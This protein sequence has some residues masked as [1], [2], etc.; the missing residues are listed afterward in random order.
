MRLISIL[1]CCLAACGDSN[2]AKDTADA[3]DDDGLIEVVPPMDVAADT[4]DDS[5][6]AITDMA[7]PDAIADI[8]VDTGP[9]LPQVEAGTSDSMPVPQAT[10][11]DAAIGFRVNG[12]VHPA[13]RPATWYVEYGATADYGAQT[14]AR[15]LPGRLAAHFREDWTEG[16]NGWNGGFQGTSLVPRVEGDRVFLRYTDMGAAE[17]DVN[18]LDGVGLIHL[19]MYGYPGNV[20]SGV[21]EQPSLYLGGG[22]PDLRGAKM[23]MSVRGVDWV[24]KGTTLGTWTQMDLDASMADQV[25]VR[26]ANWAHT[27]EPFGDLLLSGDW[28]DAHWTLRNRTVDWTYSGQYGARNAY[29][30]KELDGALG[31]VNVDIF[32]AQLLYVDMFDLPS[33]GFD[34]DTL[35]IDFRNHSVVIPSNGGSLVTSPAEGGDP[36]ALVDGFRFGDSHEWIG[37]AAPGHVFRYTLARPVTLTSV[38]IHNSVTAPSTLVEV[39]VSDDGE[40]FVSIGA[41]EI[42]TTSPYGPN[43]LFHHQFELDPVTTRELPLHDKPIVA[44]EVEILAG[45]EGADSWGLGEIEA[46]GAGAIEETED[47]WYDVNL[48]VIVPPGNYHHRIVVTTD[49]GSAHGDD[50]AIEV[51][52]PSAPT[53]ETVIPAI[54]PVAGGEY[55]NIYGTDLAHQLSIQVGGITFEP[56]GVARGIMAVEMPPGHGSCDITITTEFGTVTSEAAVAYDDGT[57]LADPGPCKLTMP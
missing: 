38:L 5:A 24:P 25:P 10:E 16:L 46:Y 44:L 52:T 7:E 22:H 45:P 18:H 37:A 50:V 2:D 51:L 9:R 53:I 6:D 33:G 55:I 15:A 21:I 27:G 29:L 47:D 40:H 26:R 56:Y 13:G 31:D 41:R 36:A 42:P 30:Y 54:V 19:P 11:N 49:A 20:Q 35:A 43:F 57:G 32:P 3:I 12:R 4:L 39:R 28:E 23:S 17:N 14:P 1:L 34:F 48:D 8:E